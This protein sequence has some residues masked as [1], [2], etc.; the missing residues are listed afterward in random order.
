[1]EF[2]KFLDDM[3]VL[4]LDYTY[5]VIKYLN[6]LLQVELYFTINGFINDLKSYCIN[7]NYL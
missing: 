3:V 7:N 1:M 6:M 2:G 4:M 5:V